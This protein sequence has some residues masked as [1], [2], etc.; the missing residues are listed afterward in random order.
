[1][2][3]MRLTYRFELNTSIEYPHEDDVKGVLFQPSG[4]DSE[5]KCVS[6]GEDK[7]FKIWE[8]QDIITPYSKYRIKRYCTT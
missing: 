2:I 4:D 1:M 3:L 5:L 7:K 8:L 6:I